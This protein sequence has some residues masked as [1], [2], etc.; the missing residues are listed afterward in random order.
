M[1]YVRTQ[2]LFSWICYLF[3]KQWKISYKITSKYAS[4]NHSRV[5]VDQN[6]WK[7]G[8][9]KKQKE[10]HVIF[11]YKVYINILWFNMKPLKEMHGTGSK[12]MKCLPSSLYK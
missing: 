4:E 10:W 7:N 5:K 8:N 2:I 3:L 9:K 1:F 11:L 6:N 12:K